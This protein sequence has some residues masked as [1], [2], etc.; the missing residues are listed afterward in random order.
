MKNNAGA[1]GG[2]EV[3]RMADIVCL[4]RLRWDFARRRPQHLMSRSAR[5]RR[6]FFVEEPVFGEA[7]PDLD[8]GRRDCGVY[9]VTPHLREGPNDAE[10]TAMEQSLL[11]NELFLEYNVCD[12]ILWYYTPVAMAFTWRLDPLLVVY[13]CIDEPPA[14][15]SAA[16][17]AGQREAELLKL[18][19]VVFTGES[20]LY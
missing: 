3:N 12:Y 5:E 10:A 8:I 15:S 11:I 2:A 14:Y 4:S 17:G 13:D 7:L 1:G 6:V 20:R 16:P 18:A 19:D 9:V